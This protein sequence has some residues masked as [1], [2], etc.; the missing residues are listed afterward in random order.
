MVCARL[1][2]DFHGVV[3]GVTVPSVFPCQIAPILRFPIF[4]VS[5]RSGI[6]WHILPTIIENGAPHYQKPLRSLTTRD[7]CR[8]L[9]RE[10]QRRLD[11]EACCS[12]TR[13]RNSVMCINLGIRRF[14]WSATVFT[15]LHTTSSQCRLLPPWSLHPQQLLPL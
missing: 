3:S 9:P 12:R 13:R 10:H 15:C 6:P 1:S 2:A 7:A 11:D 8:S 5:S 14:V 4:G